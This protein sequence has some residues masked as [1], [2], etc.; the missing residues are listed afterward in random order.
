MPGISGIISKIKSEIAQEQLTS[1][2]QSMHK[3]SMY[4]IGSYS[5]VEHEV[6]MGW[7][8]HRDSFSDCMPIENETKDIVLFFS[9]ESF[10]DREEIDVLRENGHNFDP[11][12]SSYLLHAYEEKGLYDFLRWLNGWF[13]GVI[14]DLRKGLV[15][16]FND[17]YGLGRVYFYEGKDAF[18]FSSEAKAILKV[19]P[20]TRTIDEKGLAEFFACGCVLEERTLFKG[21]KVLPAGSFWTFQKGKG[22]L[23][24]HYFQLT[25]WENQ[26]VLTKETFHKQFTSTFQ[27]VVPKYFNAKTPV[28]FSLTGGLDTR[29]ILSCWTPSGTLP[30]Y[31]FGGVSGEI[32]DVKIARKVAEVW[33]Q[34]HHTITIGRDFFSE[35]PFYAKKTISATDGTADICGCHEV[36]LNGFA[37]EIAPVRMTGNY[38]GE[39]LR[40]VSTFKV[41]HLNK[42]FFHDDFNRLMRVSEAVLDNTATNSKVSFAVLKEIPWRH[43]G[44]LQAAQSQVTV[45]TPY[46]DNEL[47]ALAYQAPP[48]ELSGNE[49]SLHI[50]RECAPD[51]SRIMTDQG[52]GGDGAWIVRAAS[53]VF[54]RFLF[55]AEY[56][57]NEGMPGFLTNNKAL[58]VTAGL[59]RLFLGRH[60]YLFYRK[61]FAH[62]LSNF[63]RDILLDS[64][65]EQRPY[66]NRKLLKIMVDRHMHGKANFTNEIGKVASIE[67]THRLMIEESVK[68]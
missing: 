25:E 11:S 50:L 39:V 59:E 56:H 45:R 6:Y 16:L 31:T 10:A 26:P 5:N 35:F 67:L 41:N 21:I 42:D 7:S 58:P 37:R 40:G 54:H 68:C 4:N 38:G 3:E 52:V 44:I 2:I 8:C 36:Y 32:Y 14:V 28:G 1:M 47:I 63:V 43:F 51:F 23:R 9:G 55:K 27:K 24:Q 65:S 60:K 62:E 48:S 30:C 22:A 53:R 49:L 46:M 64:R 12:N 18:Y 34:P 13:C 15:V 19:C 33:K 20:L 61:W 66:L 57:L 17:R 29:M